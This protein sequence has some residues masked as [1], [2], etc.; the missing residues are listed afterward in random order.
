MFLGAVQPAQGV[1]SKMFAPAQLA[2]SCS[3]VSCC[4]DLPADSRAVLGGDTLRLA[5]SG[6]CKN[7][8]PQR[9]VAVAMQ[10]NVQAVSLL[11]DR[12]AELKPR[13]LG[14]PP[15]RSQGASVFRAQ[16]ETFEPVTA[17]AFVHDEKID[18]NE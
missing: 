12:K 1:G 3:L 17:N 11:P 14:L 10:Q 15:L 5:R 16:T 13:T 2:C 7:G 18:C 4:K 8:S 9:E 6:R